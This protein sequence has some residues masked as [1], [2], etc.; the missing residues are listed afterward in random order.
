VTALYIYNDSWIDKQRT[1]AVY[2]WL[3]NNGVHP[4]KPRAWLGP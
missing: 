3:V 2:D 4:R 1:E